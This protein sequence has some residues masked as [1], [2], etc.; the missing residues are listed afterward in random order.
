MF[1]NLILGLNF[2]VQSEFMF[3]DPIT[4]YDPLISK[5]ISILID[6]VS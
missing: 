4:D 6:Y 1:L 3:S 2:K 5:K